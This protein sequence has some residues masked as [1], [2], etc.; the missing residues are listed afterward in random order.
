MVMFSADT[1]F[2]QLTYKS[3]ADELSVSCIVIDQE[4]L[5]TVFPEADEEFFQ[6]VINGKRLVLPKL[7]SME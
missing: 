6:D 7:M 1:L 4:A 5:T 2:S 3:R